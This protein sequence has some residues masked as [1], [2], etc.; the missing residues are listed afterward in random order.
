MS[1]L[2]GRISRCHFASVLTVWT[3]LPS[4]SPEAEERL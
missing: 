2:D 4:Y 3:I 1:D